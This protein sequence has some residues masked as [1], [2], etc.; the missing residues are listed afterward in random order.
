MFQN[1]KVLFRAS[2]KNLTVFKT[3]SASGGTAGTYAY[4]AY[5]PQNGSA[6][7][8]NQN[9]DFLV[10]S[11]MYDEFCITSM[12]L[13]FEPTA[14]DITFNVQG[15]SPAVTN[16]YSWV[17][18]D[19]GTPVQTSVSVPDK[20]MSYDSVKVTKVN[21]RHVRTVKLNNF[22]TDTSNPI[23]FNTSPANG[24]SQAWIN[25]GAMQF[26][27]FYTEQLAIPSA[28]GVVGQIT[29]QWNVAFRGRKSMSLTYEPLSGAIVMIPSS[30]FENLPPGN[31]PQDVEDVLRGT[32]VLDCSG[33]V[34][35][36]TSA[37]DGS[38]AVAN[39]SEGN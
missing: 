4:N 12:K 38:V 33:G 2:Y 24:G 29:V 20:I 10:Q 9:N 35:T 17:D 6:F 31:P 8:I 27:G 3:M 30:S 15:V 39:T 37:L 18:R 36:I 21:R 22:W 7:S 11:K 26:I 32:H 14:N 16:L 19:G 1:T 25:G 34:I 28:G 23:L 5:S 13:T